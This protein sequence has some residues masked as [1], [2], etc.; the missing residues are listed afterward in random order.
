MQEDFTCWPDFF[1][2]ENQESRKSVGVLGVLFRD[3]SNDAVMETFIEQDYLTAIKFEYELDQRIID[4]VK[5]TVN[6][7]SYISEVNSIIV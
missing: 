3:I 5:S 1:E 7:H 4:Q 2:K 6:M